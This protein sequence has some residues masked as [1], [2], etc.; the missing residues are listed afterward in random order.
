MY[1][2]AIS[3]IHQTQSTMEVQV[4]IN[5]MQVTSC[6]QNYLVCEADGFD[7]GAITGCGATMEQALA[8]FIENWLLRYDEL[9]SLTI[10]EKQ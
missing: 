2:D 7:L 3:L 4:I 5:P 8:D 6:P 9:I 1:Y 10:K